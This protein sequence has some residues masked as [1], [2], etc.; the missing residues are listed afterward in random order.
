MKTAP[1]SDWVSIFASPCPRVLKQQSMT[2]TEAAKIE[3]QML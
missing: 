2:A 3:W 1:L